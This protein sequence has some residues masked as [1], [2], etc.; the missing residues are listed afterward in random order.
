MQDEKVYLGSLHDSNQ[1][2]KEEGHLKS[3][4]ILQGQMSYLAMLM[5][6]SYNLCIRSVIRIRRSV[7]FAN[8][9]VRKTN[10]T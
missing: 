8:P 3:V 5:T 9:A 2:L 10:Q 6:V 4:D 7:V 1:F